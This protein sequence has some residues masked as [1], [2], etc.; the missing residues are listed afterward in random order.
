MCQG[1]STVAVIAVTPGVPLQN[2]T[3]EI[4]YRYTALHST[5]QYRTVQY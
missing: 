1:Y 2:I 5:A 4:V 3:A